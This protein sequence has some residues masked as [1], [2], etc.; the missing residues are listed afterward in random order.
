MI[1]ASAAQ[2]HWETV[3]KMANELHRRQ[4]AA[5]GDVSVMTPSERLRWARR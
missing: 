4:R 3:A 1:A 2:Q 5:A